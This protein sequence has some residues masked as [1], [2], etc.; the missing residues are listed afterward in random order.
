MSGT[1]MDAVDAALCEFLDG[2]FTG[3]V[4]A[5]STHYPDAVR[6]QLLALQSASGGL[7][8]GEI[9]DLDQ[10]VASAFAEA[11]R[12]LCEGR[13]V[14]AIGSHGQTIFHDAT[15]VRNSLQLGN[16]SMIAVKTGVPVVADFRRADMALG[17]QGAPLVPAFH[18]AAFARP[19]EPRCVLNIGGISNITILPDAANDNV[20]GW[21][22]GPG[23]ALMDEWIEFKQKLSF[24]AGG[25]WAASGSVREGLLRQLLDDPYFMRPPP[26]STGRDYFNLAWVRSRFAPMDHFPGADVQR[27]LCEL[28]AQIVSNSVTRHAPRTRLL[29]VCGG[30][31]RNL[32]LMSRLRD[33]QPGMAVEITDDHKLGADR[34]EAAAFAWLAM[35]RMD[36]L[37]GSLPAVT[38]AR[39]AAILGGIFSP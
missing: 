9:A 22:I 33:L 36:G 17:G 26:K 16:P 25:A 31:A 37:T 6:K 39:R 32:L 10:S 2:R 35:R 14:R 4:D 20:R 18:H 38:G 19:D 11:A 29:L 5:R 24:D 34:V 1:S 7:G 8:L 3:V 21:D 15:G 12:P 28:T 27:T 23:N 13:H 30:G